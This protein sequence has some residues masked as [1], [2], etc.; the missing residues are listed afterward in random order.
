MLVLLV[1][2]N[3]SEVRNLST[4]RIPFAGEVSRPCSTVAFVLLAWSAVSACRDISVSAVDVA[5]VELE[6]GSVALTVGESTTIDVR[7]LDAR[8]RLVTGR[9]VSWASETPA[10]AAIDGSGRVT[11]LSP[12]SGVIVATVEGVRAEAA[13]TISA[14]PAIIVDPSVVTFAAQENGL[15]PPAES[16]L[17]RADGPLDGLSA[18]IGH[19]PGRPSGW[20]T[21]RLSDDAAPASLTLSATTDGL[22]PGQYDATVMLTAPDAAA[23]RTLTVILTVSP[24]SPVIELDRSGVEIQGRQGAADPPAQTVGVTNAGGG[25]LTGLNATVSYPAGEPIGWLTAGVSNTTAPAEIILSATTG[26]LAPGTWSAAVTVTAGAASIS[27]ASILVTLVVDAAGP[28]IAVAPSTVI[29]TTTA[30]GPDP[31]P[32][33]PVITNGGGGVLT[34]LSASVRHPPGQPTGWLTA[35]VSTATAP[36]TLPL[37]AST[38]SLPAGTYTAFVDVTAR[39][40]SNSPYTL[41]ATLNVNSAAMAPAIAVSPGTLSFDATVG[42]SDPA[43][44]LVDVNNAGGGILDGLTVVVSYDAGQPTGWLSA[45][46]VG[47]TAPTSIAV[48]PVTG[49]LSPGQYGATIDVSSKAASNSPQSIDVTFTVS[50]APAPPAAP[51]LVEASDGGSHVRLRWQDNSS[52]ET[53]FQVQRRSWLL[54]S[55]S[56][57]ATVPADTTAYDDQ[58]AASSWTYYYRVAACNALGCSISNTLGVSTND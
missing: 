52:N 32:A 43:P 31:A 4:N 39:D 33:F 53:S 30:G 41:T 36:S 5:Q 11:G 20:L 29:L 17:V 42:G 8:G 13:V 16:V 6:P 49:T 47:A 48:Q 35:S 3:P 22:A 15:S 25:S 50:P 44:G 56:T 23:D 27:P 40:A 19:A 37:T 2:M 55:W 26:S 57:V 14:K 34:G 10:V 24:G 12:G 45:V 7:L 1:P 28:V 18:S 51:T 21:V 46:P 9:Q 58:G 38:A 54:G